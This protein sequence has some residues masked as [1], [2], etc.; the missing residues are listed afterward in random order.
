MKRAMLCM[1]AAGLVAGIPALAGAQTWMS[2]GDRTSH[3]DQ[4]IDLSMK[5]GH[6]TSAEAERARMEFKT[7]QDLEAFYRTGGMTEWERA[8]L[9][10]RYSSLTGRMHTGEFTGTALTATAVNAA[11]EAPLT[12]ELITNGPVPDTPENRARYGGPLS[13]A[14]RLTAPIGN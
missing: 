7:L 10:F 5:A 1:V 13:R 4:R 14:G 3:L 8:D 11:D 6:L 9:D 12:V 2:I